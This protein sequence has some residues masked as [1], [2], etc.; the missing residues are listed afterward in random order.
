MEKQHGLFTIDSFKNYFL[1]TIVINTEKPTTWNQ[2]R[3]LV[4]F[5]IICLFDLAGLYFHF[6]KNVQEDLFYLLL[7]SLIFYIVFPSF[8]LRHNSHTVKWTNLKCSIWQM[9]T[10]E[11][12]TTTVIIQNIYISSKN[13]LLSVCRQSPPTQ[14]SGHGQ[15]LSCFLSP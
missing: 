4:S 13:F 12:L 11:Q 14:F 3:P 2:Q 1:N 15:P 9:Y 7:S 6:L 5:G 8:L 10:V